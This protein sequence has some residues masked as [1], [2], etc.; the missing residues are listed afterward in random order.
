MRRGLNKWFSGYW[1]CYGNLV[2]YFWCFKW[3]QFKTVWVWYGDE[4]VRNK[5]CGENMYV[6]GFY[7]SVTRKSKNVLIWPDS[8][9][10]WR[11]F[12]EG[13]YKYFI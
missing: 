3:W 6:F 9:V 4:I 13:N 11:F 2:A 10:S 7:Y 8:Q 12:T 1:L 5:K